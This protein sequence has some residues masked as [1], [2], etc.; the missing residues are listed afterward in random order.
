MLF[1]IFQLKKRRKNVY[2][3]IK[4]MKLAM[5]WDVVLIAQI[6]LNRGAIAKASK[7]SSNPDIL[8]IHV[9]L[10]IATVLLYI[11]V[12]RFG[13]KLYSGQRSYF[14]RHKALGVLTLIMRIATLITS[15]YI[16]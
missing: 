5:V 10:A 7:L 16:L 11:F 15:F 12:Y 13:K 1:G 2:K 6:E 9:S 14:G 3:H 8:N 4:M